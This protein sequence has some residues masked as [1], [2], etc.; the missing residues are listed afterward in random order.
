MRNNI[1]AELK[2]NDLSPQIETAVKDAVK[3]YRKDA[4]FKNEGIWNFSCIAQ[5]AAQ[6][7]NF[8]NIPGASYSLPEDFV[9]LEGVTI[10]QNGAAIPLEERD[11][12]WYLEQTQG[13]PV[14]I[15]GPTD[16]LL[17]N[18]QIFLWPVPDQTYPGTVW[19]Q[20]ALPFPK[21]TDDSNYWM[22]ADAEPMIRAKAEA[23][24]Y[25]KVLKNPQM[26]QVCE[27]IAQQAYDRIQRAAYA[28]LFTGSPRSFEW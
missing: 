16:Y 5:A 1:A 25:A 14:V 20:R 10:V 21:A 19:Y 3:F 23:F 26:A 6:V 8:P 28:N 22:N 11:L 12:G 7:Y 4:L 18:N 15:G 27:A 13:N 17:F 24:I 9:E 2:R